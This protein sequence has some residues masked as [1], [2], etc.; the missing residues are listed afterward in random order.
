M[1]ILGPRSAGMH[2]VLVVGM[3]LGGGMFLLMLLGVVAALAVPRLAA[4][5]EA[6]AHQ[7]GLS[8][9]DSAVVREAIRG[10]RSL[11]ELQGDH[12]ASHGGYTRNLTDPAAADY[13]AEWR[14]PGAQ[15][16]GFEVSSL[17]EGHL[18]IG[19]VP[20][21]PRSRALPVSI[22]GAGVLYA[23]SDCA[24]AVISE[25]AGVEWLGP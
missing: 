3:V 5:A 25:D 15:H 18:C 11:Y 12:M 23:D 24:G 6:E 17:E 7:P 22:D 14:D 10:L 16:Y 2:P 9:A 21:S 13:L 1:A 20:R 8:A 4:D 19:A